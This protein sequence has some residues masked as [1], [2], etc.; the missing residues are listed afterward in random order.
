MKIK[1]WGYWDAASDGDAGGAGGGAAAGADGG[2]A[3]GGS[4]KGAAAEPSILSLGADPA[5]VAA[6]A[7]ASGADPAKGGAT[8]PKLKDDPLAWLPERFRVKGEGDALNF[9]ESGKKVAQAYSELEKRMKDTGLPPETADKYEFKPPKGMEALQLDGEMTTK[10]KQGLHAL[11][12]SQ[13]QYQG[14]MEMYVGSLNDMVERG[15]EIGAKKATEV[16]A[17]SW[18][19]PD[20]DQFKAQNGLAYKAFM[21]FADEGDK[22]ELDKIG[23]NPVVLKILAKVGREL[24]EDQVQAGQILAA[25][26]LE[27]LMKDPAYFNANDPRHAEV[28]AKVHRHFQAQADAQARQ[29]AA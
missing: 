7:A 13:K 29:Q 5:A 28:K 18:G 20:S 9:E 16:L 27:Q 15:T 11:G 2:A 8:E 1:H 26:S 25:E 24:R 17:K 21:A 10:A 22:A 4:S 19:A 14:V 3:G 6:A 12:L 23:N